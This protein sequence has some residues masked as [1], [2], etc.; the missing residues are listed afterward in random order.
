M[1]F[2]EDKR[3]FR[4]DEKIRVKVEGFEALVEQTSESQKEQFKNRLINIKGNVEK[5]SGRY[6]IGIEERIEYKYI[7]SETKKVYEASGYVVINKDYSTIDVMEQAKEEKLNICS[8]KKKQ[9]RE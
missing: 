6:E 1:V 5:L 4:V 8:W 3:S 9:S 2:D 7:S